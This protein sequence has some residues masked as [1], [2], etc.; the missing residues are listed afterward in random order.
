MSLVCIWERCPS[1]S[2][3]ITAFSDA[4]WASDPDDRRSIR[5][6]CVLLGTNLVS[7][8]SK[9]QHTVARSFI[10]AEYR[11]LAQVVAE[12]SWIKALLGELRVKEAKVPEVWCDN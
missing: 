3:D 4:D 8:C 9:K 6:Y 5:G 7:W 1:S 10:E 11:S 12:I 2:L